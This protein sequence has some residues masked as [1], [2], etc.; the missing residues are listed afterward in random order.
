MGK[1]QRAS[2]AV[3]VTR[4]GARAGGSE[5]AAFGVARR[6]DLKPNSRSSSPIGPSKRTANL[7]GAASL[8]TTLADLSGAE[9]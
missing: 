8:T 7:P 9:G 2:E 5:C 6:F 3:R 4:P 1:S